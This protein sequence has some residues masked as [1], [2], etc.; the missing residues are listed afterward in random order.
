MIYSFSLPALPAP[1]V[2]VPPCQPFPSSG[3]KVS[4]DIC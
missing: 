4:F 1:P 2:S 3:T